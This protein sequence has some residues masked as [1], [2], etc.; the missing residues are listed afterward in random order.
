MQKRMKSFSYIAILLMIFFISCRSS[1]KQTDDEEVIYD[2]VVDQPDAIE[3]LDSSKTVVNIPS[4]WKVEFREKNQQEKLEKPAD[5]NLAA[6][7]PTQLVDA[8]NQTYPDI[9]LDFKNISHDTAYVAIPESDRLTSQI[10]ST[11]AYNY[12]ATTVYNLTEL[13]GVKFV[14]FAFSEGDHAAPGTYSRDDFKRLR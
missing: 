13:K 10:G 2:S 9:H 4:L 11:G 6:L 12:M 1:D 5:N 14:N 8:L 7:G 3:P